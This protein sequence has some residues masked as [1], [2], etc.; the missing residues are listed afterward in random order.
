MIEINLSSDNKDYS[1]YENKFI[2]GKSSENENEN[3][4]DVLVFCVRNVKNVVIP[5]FIKTIGPYSFQNCK[6]IYEIIFE[7]NSKLERIGKCA[8]QNSSIKTLV[9]PPSLKIICRKAFENCDKLKL[10]EIPMDSEIHTIQRYAFAFSSIE[11]INITSKLVKLE[12]FW[13]NDTP[14]LTDRKSVV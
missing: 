5:K 6:Q 8:F 9:T 4:F 11:S 2:I 12:K 7:P 10:V 3:D 1:L 13:C 14:K